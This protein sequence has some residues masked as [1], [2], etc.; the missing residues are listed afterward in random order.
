MRKKISRRLLLLFI[1]IFSIGVSI[2]WWVAD[3]TDKKMRA[4]LLLHSKIAAQAINIKYVASLSGS[5]EDLNKPA[6]QRIKSQLASMRKAIDNCRFLYLMGRRS[7]GEVFFFM[8]SL[9]LDSKDYAP[10]GLVYEEVSDSYIRTF[11]SNMEAVVGPVTDRWGTLITA[12]APLIDPNQG[13]LIAVLGMDIDAKHWNEE[14]LKRC[15][16]PFTITLLFMVLILLLFSR[17]K[18]AKSFRQSENKLRATLDAT[19]FP[20]ALIDLNDDKIFYWSHSALTLFGH[21]A[22]TTSEWYQIAYPDPDYRKEVLEKWKSFLNKA[23]KTGQPINTGEY[24]VTCKDGS[25]R[26]CELYA[27][28]LPENLIVTFNDIT[29]RKRAEEDLSQIFSMSLDMIC[30]ADINT[31]TLTKVNPAFTQILGYSEEE[32][33]ERPFLDF[34]HPDDID[35][36]LSVIEKKLKAGAKVINFENRYRCKDGSY[37]WLSWVGQPSR[38]LG[39]TYSV[40]RDITEWK[41]NEETLKKNKALLDATGRMAKV[42]GWELDANTLE[43]TWT[44]EIYRIHDVPVGQKPS[45]KEAINFF[46]PEDRPQLEQAIQRA[47]DHGEPYDT[48]IRFV[49]GKGKHLWTRT[50]CRPE[51]RNGKTVKLQGTFQDITERKQAQISLMALKRRNQALL[52]HSP[53]CHKI[54]DLDFNLTY[55]SMSGFKMLKLDYT[56]DVYGQPYPFAFFPEAFRREMTECLEKVK[57]TMETVTNEGLARDSGGSDVWLN[58]TLVPVKN[59]D[60]GLAYIT[61]VSSD[62]SQWK[63]EEENRKRLEERLSQAQKMEAIGNLAGGIAHDFNNIL[64]PITGLAELL[65]ED[66]SPDSFE[67]ENARQIYKAGQRGGDL[68]QQIMAFSRQTEHKLIPVKV[69]QILREVM[70]LSRSAIPS[71]IE[72]T[73]EIRQDCGTV[74][75]DPTQVHQIAMNIITNAYHA[76]EE[77][78]GRISVSLNEME[79][80]DDDLPGNA[81]ESG[82]YAQLTISDTGHGMPSEVAARIFDPYFTTKEAGQGHRPGAGGGLRHREGTQGGYPGVQ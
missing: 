58:A 79:L 75:A 53:L 7:D 52:D 10:P 76:V 25:E 69:Q 40:A 8:D 68:V 43:V 9:P 56:A 14:I 22:S 51:T 3:A 64:F 20:V 39:I 34:V 27:T 59:D 71:N 38:D 73:Q 44:D 74:M 60:G 31:A 81:L 32:L 80:T 33:L 23:K 24:R 46:H 35:A 45:L 13:N 67:H 16:F 15:F 63:R 72:L 36:T 4:E 5:M 41:Q 2:I 61:V 47:L 54:V 82:R 50:I 49:S 12:L 48:E 30:I 65:M 19:P 28:F 62:I 42:G 11:D 70:K 66:L 1:C 78:G 77:R 6:Y 18:V 29:D 37:R 26:S 17:E 21:T 55:M 57:R